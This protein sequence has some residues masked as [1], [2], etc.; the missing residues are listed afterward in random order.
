MFLIEHVEAREILDSRGNPTLQVDVIL[1]EGWGRASVPSGASTGTFEALELRD[2]DARYHGKGVQKAVAHVNGEIREALVGLE[3]SGFYEVDRILRALD[4]TP[5]KARLGANAILGVSLACA[6]AMAHAVGLPLYRYIGGERGR[7]LPTPFMNV[8]NGGAHADNPL[9]IQEFMIVPGGA[10]SFR[11]ALRWGAEVFHTLKRLL[12]EQGL[13]TA[14]GDE[15]GFA[16]QIASAREVLDLLLSAIEKS[17]YRPGEDIAL[18]LDV[19]ATELLEDGRYRM[20]GQLLDRDAWIRFFEDL[21]RDYP[22]VSLEDPAAEEDWETWRAMTEAL[23][24]RV[25]IVGDDVFVTNPERLERGMTSGVATAILIKPNQIGTLSETV[26]V[27]EM[28]FR[29][30][31]GAMVSHRSGETEDTTI[32]DLA[33]ALRTGMIKTGSL[34]RSDRLAKYNRLLVIEEELGEDAEFTGFALIR[35]RG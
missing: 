1:D 3:V 7:T 2:G 11:E 8:V 18:A 23:A 4:G 10:P 12:K 29:N 33:V 17:G 27:V 35:R 32:A 28:A 14:V 20:E 19:A 31:Y 22:L 30:G 15:G 24:G 13:S 21:V 6:H 34:S 5:N 26:E 16:P 25:Q 9:D